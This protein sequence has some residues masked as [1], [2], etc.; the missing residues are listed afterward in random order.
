MA[1]SY[2]LA[3]GGTMVIPD[4][5]ITVTVANNP[6]GA[7]TQGIVALVG[8]ASSGP[9]W[10]QDQAAG[11]KLSL[12]T[13]GVGDIQRVVAKY[14]SGN[15]VDAFRGI[16]SPS[17]SQQITGGPQTIILVKTNNS[18]QATYQTADNWGTYTADQGGAQGDGIQVSITSSQPEEAPSTGNFSY[19]PSASGSALAARVNGGAAQTLSIAANTTPT[20]LAAALSGL[21][22]ISAVGGVNIGVLGRSRY[23]NIS[24]G[25]C[26]WT[27]MYLLLL[28]VQ[29]F[30]PSS[31]SV[32]DTLNIPSGSVLAGAGNAN[33][34]WYLV[35][36]VSN[37][38]GAA[39]IGAQLIS[40]APAPVAVAPV[41]I[42]AT[43]NN[44]LADYS[45]ITINNVSGTNRNVLTGLTT[46]NITVSV[47]GSS[48]TA[49][50]QVGQVFSGIPTV[51]D[52]VY[53]PAGSAFEGAGN[54]NVGWY[55]VTLVSNTISQAFIQ[56]SR[57]SNGTPVAV[58]STP[59][60][61]TTDI[62]DYDTQ[63]K[64]L[65][66]SMEIYDNGGAVNIDTVMFNLG[67]TTEASW[68]QH[69]Q[70]SAA[71]LQKTFQDVRNSTNSNETY[72]VGGNIGLTI[73]YAGTSATMTIGLV[74]GILTLTTSI[75]GGP[76]ANLNINL[77]KVSTIGDLAQMISNQPGYTASAGTAASGQ[78]NPNQLDE[79]TWAID[80]SLGNM[81][82][83]IKT[84]Y[85]DLVSGPNGLSQSALITL[86]PSSTTI[87]GLP[88]DT[89]A[90]FLTGGENGGT[91]GLQAS[92][93]I[94]ALQGVRTN[95]VV[96]LFSQDA[97]KDIAAGLTDP[98]STYTVDAINAAVKAHVLAMSTPTIKRHRVGIVSKRGTFAQAM[99]SAQTMATFR[100]AETFMDVVDLNAQGALYQFQPWYGSCKAAGMQAAGAYK[101]IFNKSINISGAIQAA[102]D[103]DD[104][105][106][107]QTITALQAGL[108]PITL[109]DTGGYTFV[110]DQMTYSLDNNFVYNS[111][112]AVYVADLMALD[113]ASS[114][115]NAFVSQSVADVTP[116]AVES[117]VKA[118]MAQYLSLK[119]TVGSPQQGAPGGW[120]SISI[121][122]I[123]G[124]L[125]VAV[126]AIEATSIYFIPINLDIEGIQA[127]TTAT[128]A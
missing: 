89:S 69:L 7:V 73:G 100:I 59:I 104:E 35:T 6:T 107:T 40:S 11:N 82:G 78:R 1:F 24:I 48:L 32:G 14:G 8:E 61:A 80:S 9:S 113:L 52:L 128:G 27:P 99:T 84:D 13:Y 125:Q 51:S 33:V 41:A 81:P 38:S 108:I 64:G 31:P 83:R 105:N 98:S 63:I 118:K 21:S 66:K 60:A 55:Q 75:V 119:Y 77:T 42:S 25:C 15:L 23:S 116:G 50:L 2:T 54:A 115:R 57:L 29:M 101:S 3:N 68:L 94:D 87:A 17:A 43:P 126:V 106:V 72:T 93:A 124:V 20:A 117:F 71:E 103:Y 127:S 92:Q 86:V 96:P 95:F 102:G 79:G 122:I 34:G 111:L 19:I 56:M 36:S 30:S 91:T 112:Q 26:F 70:V 28:L 114:L 67:T 58:S 44:D 62:Q 120:K 12:N 109:Q 90:Q 121:N 10:S 22:N 5:A 97:S 74:G 49:T 110:S 39:T 45:S 85:Y 53:I 76:G 16:I 37:V 4:S 88:I 47:A 46:K 65:G 123:P 18:T